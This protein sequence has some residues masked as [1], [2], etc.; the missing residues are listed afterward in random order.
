M[1]TGSMPVPLEIADHFFATMLGGSFANH[2]VTIA[3][4]SMGVIDSPDSSTAWGCD[5]TKRTRVLTDTNS[6]KRKFVFPCFNGETLVDEANKA[7]VSWK[8]YAPAPGDLG[9]LWSTFD[10][11]RHIRFSSQWDTNVVAPDQF[12]RDVNANTLPALSWL[13]AP[14]KQS[15]HPPASICAGQAW[16]VEQINAVMK[17]PAWSSTVIILTW[18]DFGGFYDHVSPPR[19]TPYRLLGRYQRTQRS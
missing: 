9:Y 5:S 2:L 6:G 12:Q 3:G 15:D 10:A 11:V 7:G 13:V 18:D 19:Q 4:Q 16:T 1:T 17:S 8:Y 14:L